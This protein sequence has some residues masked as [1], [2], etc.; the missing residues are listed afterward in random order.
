MATASM[1]A[2]KSTTSTTAA[3][4]PS[5]FDL[6]LP[7]GKKARLYRMLYQFGP[8]NGT[9]VFLPLITADT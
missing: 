2:P 1:T 6:D 4:R 9:F 5:L 7:A 8:A 3:K